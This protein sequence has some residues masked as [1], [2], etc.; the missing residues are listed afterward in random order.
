MRDGVFLLFLLNRPPSA[1]KGL[2]DFF[3]SFSCL[4]RSRCFVRIYPT[5]PLNSHPSIGYLLSEPPSPFFAFPPCYCCNT[6]VFIHSCGVYLLIY[7]NRLYFNTPSIGCYSFPPQLHHTLPFAGFR[8]TAQPNF[9]R[10]TGR[11]CM[12]FPLSLPPRR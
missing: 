4:G 6:S 11:P 3:P 1:L 12:P 5:Q 9:W 7:D 8:S 2:Q 10:S